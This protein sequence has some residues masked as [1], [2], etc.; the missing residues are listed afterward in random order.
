MSPPKHAEA[1]DPLF[2]TTDEMEVGPPNGGAVD[3]VTQGTLV[4]QKS[5]KTDGDSKKRRRED[6]AGAVNTEKEEE[7]EMKRNLALFK[8]SNRAP[9][10]PFLRMRALPQICSRGILA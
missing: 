5:E 4:T 2:V 10:C 8:K 9:F 1:K 7:E 3:D 6:G